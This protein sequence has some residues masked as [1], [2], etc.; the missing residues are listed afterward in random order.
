MQEALEQEEL[1]VPLRP[2]L[3]DATQKATEL[4]GKATG[5]DDKPPPPPRE[6]PGLPTEGEVSGAEAKEAVTELAGRLDD[7]EELTVSWKL[8]GD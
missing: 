6:G 2:R 5:G 1:A 8:K 3:E 4:L 7:I